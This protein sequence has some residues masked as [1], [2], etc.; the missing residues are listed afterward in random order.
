MKMM[1]TILISS[2]IL[3]TTPLWA[4]TTTA[5]ESTASQTQVAPY[6]DNPNIFKVLGHKAQQSLENTAEKVDHG[7]QKGVAKV[8]PKVENAWENSKEF[9][10]EKSE[11]AKEKTQ[12]AAVSVN[13]KLN[14]TKDTILGSP[15]DQP[16]PIVSRPLSQSSTESSSVPVQPA[17]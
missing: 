17:S 12:Q 10:T 11:M 7:L 9:A 13:K 15:N 4:Q 1:K 3:A 16:A 6:G 14:E 8:K 5:T 2:T